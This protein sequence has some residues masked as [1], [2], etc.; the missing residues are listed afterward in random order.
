ME[1]VAAMSELDNK[2]TRVTVSIRSGW[3]CIDD[4]PH[5]WQPR[6]NGGKRCDRCQCT[7]AA[8]AIWLITANY[9]QLGVIQKHCYSFAEA[10]EQINR[11]DPI[12]SLFGRCF[13]QD[14][15]TP[16][17]AGQ[18]GDTH[19]DG[20][21]TGVHFDGQCVDQLPH[22]ERTTPMTSIEDNIDDVVTQ[23]IKATAEKILDMPDDD[24]ISRIVK[25][26]A[27][28]ILDMLDDVI[29]TRR[30]TSTFV[31]ENAKA[32]SEIPHLT[33]L[34]D[35]IPETVNGPGATMEATE[36]LR[37]E[38]PGL[39]QRHDIKTVL[40]VGCGDW[41]WMQ[42]VDL[43]MIQSYTGWDVDAATIEENQRRFAGRTNVTFECK[44]LLTEDA[45]PKVDLILARHVLIHFPNAYTSQIL[46]RFKGSG[47]TYLLTST[48][49]GDENSDKQPDGFAYRGY[50]E[51]TVNL[52]ADPFNLPEIL[53]SIEEP[54]AAAGV[55]RYSHYLALFKLPPRA[56]KT[57]VHPASE[58]SSGAPQSISFMDRVTEF[59]RRVDEAQRTAEFPSRVDEAR[60]L[61]A[62]TLRS[63]AERQDEL[64]AARDH[65][66]EVHQIAS[67][68]DS[69]GTM[70]LVLGAQTA[71]LDA[72]LKHL[73]GP[74]TT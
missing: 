69:P 2:E 50:M 41:T 43:S 21:T 26:M 35:P 15:V 16:L 63:Q 39:L 23:T 10:L 25:A 38:L 9:P 45:I 65:L 14:A 17:S 20:E 66:R 55:L 42:H 31:E 49:P 60:E 58:D 30:T 40:D 28:K 29:P 72:I 11:P 1:R 7:E 34:S 57:R 62:D 51:R 44:N 37:K 27:E 67:N 5:D 59:K 3:R 68:D 24:D 54:P 64:R 74:D 36:Q 19:F 12:E 13:V 48:W 53:D 47:S 18:I 73:A 22:E 70:W 52:E 6:E 71:A 4:G 56:F 8:P 46:E 32:W 61:Y 33:K